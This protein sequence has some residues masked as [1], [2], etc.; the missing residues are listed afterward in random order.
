M[1]PSAQIPR[2]AGSLLSHSLRFAKNTFQFYEEAARECGDIFTTRIP[3]LGDWVY[4]CSPDLIQAML[5]APPEVLAGGE[6]NRESMSHMLGTGATSYL[7]GPAHRERRGVTVPYLGRE[8]SLAHVDAVREITERSLAEWPDGRPFKLT[9]PLQRIALESIVRA[10]F[11]AAS[12]DQVRQLARDFESFNFKALRSPTV[13]HPTF[14]IDLGSWG[15]WGRVKKMRGEILE[16]FARAI[17]ARLADAGDGDDGDLVLG[18]ARA[19]LADGSG[20]SADAIRAEIL[21][22]LFQGHELTGNSMTWT[23]GE[24]LA[25]PPILERLR[26][27]LDS[28]VG[29]GD[30]RAAHLSR[31]EYLEAVLYEGLRF[32]P[33]TPY[34]AVRRVKQPFSLGGYELP[35]GTLLALCYPAQA[36]REQ[37]FAN[38]Q[39]FDPDRFLGKRPGPYEWNPF[40][41]GDHGC[42]GRELA[43]AI[44]KTALATIVRK[45]ELR[46]LQEE[47]KPVRSA[48]FYEPNKGLLVTVQGRR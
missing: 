15:G 16:V 2:P 28:V 21:D 30:V 14:Q 6:M 31:L 44:M 38:P 17:E 24:V 46:R 36:K 25:R 45:V 33:V 18:M 27:E 3:G 13:A 4:V 42:M 22:M 1:N 37:T 34:T 43:E 32:R 10:L 11:S 47:V 5:E 26:E 39:E 35:E 41:G 20:L 40:G 19:R 7:D 48:Y 12:P 29:D 8:G 9:E 23:L